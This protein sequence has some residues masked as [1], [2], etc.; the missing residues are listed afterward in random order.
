MGTVEANNIFSK[1]D[2][3]GINPHDNDTLVITVHIGNWDIKRILIDPGSSI[4]F[5]F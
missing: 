4:D 5:L 2:S 3:L 1:E